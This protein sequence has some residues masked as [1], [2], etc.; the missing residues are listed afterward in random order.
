MTTQYELVYKYTISLLHSGINVARSNINANYV[1]KNNNNNTKH[2]TLRK[3]NIG[4][5]D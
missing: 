4:Q 1:S 2:G 3:Q 5:I